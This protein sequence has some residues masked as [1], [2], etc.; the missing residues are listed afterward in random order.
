[1][2]VTWI[3]YKNKKI[4]FSDYRGCHNSDE[5]ISTLNDEL[6]ILENLKEK[7]LILAD[8]TDSYGSTPYI[9]YLNKVGN[10]IIKKKNLKTATL[11]ITGFKEAFFKSYVFFTN[12]K[13]VKAF[14][15]K[16]EALKWLIK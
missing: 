6:N 9:E 1:M 10:D 4:L 13:N 14:N 2:P 3:E 7:T 15:S 5:M 16:E 8:Y 12:Q 11:G